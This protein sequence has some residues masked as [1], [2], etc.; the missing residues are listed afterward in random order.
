MYRISTIVGMSFLLA[1][2]ALQNAG[3]G[4]LSV[5]TEAVSLNRFFGSGATLVPSDAFD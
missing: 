5:V 1:E 4:R 2:C 3:F